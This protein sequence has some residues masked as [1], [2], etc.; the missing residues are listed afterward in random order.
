MAN[1]LTDYFPELWLTKALEVYQNNTIM[2]RNVW[3]DYN[4]TAAQPGDVVNVNL[5][6]AFSTSSKAIGS[7]YVPADALTTKTA[8]L[9]DKHEYVQFFIYDA[10]E[11]KTPTKLVETYIQ[12][13][14]VA[15]AEKVDADLCALYA[16]ATTA[17]SAGAGTAL[18][19][20]DVTLA[21]KTLNGFKA[22]F[23]GR[24]LVV[25]T[26]AD[27]DL[28][29]D[30]TFI[31]ANRRGDGGSALNNAMLGRLYGFDIMVNQSIVSAATVAHNM[32]FV[33]QA[34][35]LV[36]RPLPALDP[37]LG[38]LR[39]SQNDPVSG[40]NMSATLAYDNRAGAISVTLD[41]VYGVKTVRP[42]LLVDVQSLGT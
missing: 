42:D 12:P 7:D 23:N 36:T 27:K 31:Q 6:T 9:L 28:L 4:M 19:I 24:V 1:A 13:A 14:M 33:P 2:A 10:E 18:A 11:L 15:I 32:A 22:P 39:V 37:G 16:D 35:A 34:L 8:I 3:T 30:P 41:I 29:D 5:P 21:R 40:V 38:A 20:S 25:G 26:D 17:L